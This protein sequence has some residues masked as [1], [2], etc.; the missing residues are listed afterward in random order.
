MINKRNIIKEYEDTI[1]EN[2]QE[3]FFCTFSN[4]YNNRL[5]KSGDGIK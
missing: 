3:L 4:K 2:I 5:N 1:K